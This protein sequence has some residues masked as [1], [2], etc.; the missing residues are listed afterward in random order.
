MTESELNSLRQNINTGIEYEYALFYL[1]TSSAEK[2]LFMKSVILGHNLESKILDLVRQ[3]DVRPI[4]D[5]FSI[6]SFSPTKFYLVTQD[7]SIGPADV[8]ASNDIDEYL[9]L[10]VKYANSCSLNVSGIHFLDK[11][12]I[13]A[14]RSQL[15][16]LYDEY[17]DEMVTIHGHK[18]NWFRQRKTSSKTDEIIDVIREAVIDKW[19]S[20]SA[21]EKKY[22][23]TRL[24]QADS[25][26]KYFIVT[27]KNLRG[28]LV[29]LVNTDLE[30]DLNYDFVQLSKH[31]TSFIRF[32]H[33]DIVIGD[34]QVKFNNGILERGTV[35]ANFRVVD[36]EFIKRGAP[37]SSWN[38]SLK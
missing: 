18:D 32:I 36:G 22:L 30:Y 7:D 16:H 29:T 26:I 5:A 21:D 3:I 23:M 27:F 2:E 25:P 11:E 34:M 14:L 12:G 33:D 19:N 8:V 28:N 35:R 10:S 4:N 15:D 6:A 31:Q 1:L 20:K 9:G 17:V 24:L 13:D 37:F 38:F